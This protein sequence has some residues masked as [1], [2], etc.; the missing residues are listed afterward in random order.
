MDTK[1]I[2]LDLRRGGCG[3]RHSQNFADPASIGKIYAVKKWLKHELWKNVTQ[4][5]QYEEVQVQCQEIT[6][7]DIDPLF[8]GALMRQCVAAGAR[9][10]GVKASINGL[11]FDWN[12]DADAQ[13]LHVTCTRKPFF[14]TCLEVESKIH[15]QM[16]QAKGAI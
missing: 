16:A 11:E 5:P 9:F 3:V 7:E 6:F 15:E 2:I 14:V 10:D 13:V 4:D 8:Y 12:Y 1:I